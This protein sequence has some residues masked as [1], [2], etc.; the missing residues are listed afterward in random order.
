MNMITCRRA[1]PWFQVNFRSKSWLPLQ[2]YGDANSVFKAIAFGCIARSCIT[3][4]ER[5]Q[6]DSEVTKRCGSNAAGQP[7]YY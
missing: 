3:N 4:E 1:D 5:S 2:P 6:T 7:L